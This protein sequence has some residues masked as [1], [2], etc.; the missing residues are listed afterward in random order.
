MASWRQRVLGPILDG[1]RD[2]DLARTPPLGPLAWQAAAAVAVALAGAVGLYL[3][4]AW[5]LGVDPRSDPAEP[6]ADQQ[7]LLAE[8]VKIALGLAAGVGASVALIIGYR[9]ARVE[10]AGSHRDDRRLFSSRYQDAADLLG[11]DKAAVRLAGVYAMSR[12]AD[13]WNEQR[14]QCIDVLCAYLRLP[15]DPASGDGGEREVRLTVVRLIGAHL[16]PSATRPW[17][18]HDLD[19]TG[20]VFDGG[21]FSGAVFSGG[22]R[23]TGAVFVGR[24]VDFSGAEFADGTADFTGARFTE[25]SVNFG[26]ARFTGSTV[27]FTEAQ[28]AG[29]SLSF[30][31][32]Q[33]AAGTVSFSG[34]PVVVDRSRDTTFSGS[35]VNFSRANFTGGRVDFKHTKFASGRLGFMGATFCGSTV[36]FTGAVFAGGTVSFHSARF[37]GGEVNL[38]AAKLAAKGKPPQ[39]LPATANR[40]LRLPDWLAQ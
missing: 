4:L 1:H 10:E 24:P 35:H 28:F 6:A 19:F 36:D 33:F 38:S 40:F 29:G 17:H 7:R 3:L 34:R 31:R 16:Q 12:L 21:D 32:A 8:L 18:G 39:D 23:F 9:R 13:D 15:Y 30:G 22:V 27:R 5:L 2:R 14:Q 25:G 11:H 37:T 26:T 20:A